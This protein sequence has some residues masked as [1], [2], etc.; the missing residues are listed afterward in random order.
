[1]LNFESPQ[2][3]TCGMFSSNVIIDEY[4][5]KPRMLLFL[6]PPIDKPSF[7]FP[8]YSHACL[9]LY[10]LTNK[11]VIKFIDK[12]FD[13]LLMPFA[14]DRNEYYSRKRTE[15]IFVF[16][17]IDTGSSVKDK[18]VINN[19]EAI[20]KFKKKIADLNLN[21]VSF[22]GDI[23]NKVFCEFIIDKLIQK[24]AFNLQTI[25]PGN[26]QTVSNELII[27]T[28][29]NVALFSLDHS[30]I[31]TFLGHYKDNAIS[32]RYKMSILG[33]KVFRM[34]FNHLDK[35]FIINFIYDISDSSRLTDTFSSI[36]I[37]IQFQD[38]PKPLSIIECGSFLPDFH[39]TSLDFSNN[40]KNLVIFVTYLSDGNDGPHRF[41]LPDIIFDLCLFS[42]NLKD[43][44]F[45]D[46]IITEFIY[47]L[48]NYYV[49]QYSCTNNYCTDCGSVIELDS[50]FCSNC[51]QLLI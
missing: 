18:L 19:E 41:K 24:G 13:K 42:G 2:D 5:L 21:V 34:Y 22:K 33:Y 40:D 37:K 46:S 35:L 25:T 10:S 26:S 14:S 12:N 1:M 39:G 43:V 3:H 20:T 17:E 27:C 45:T 48:E 44:D 28:E 6:F 38:S 50:L 31:E 16:I 15:Y 7:H 32:F 49:K 29:I 51:G 11:K 30:L 23:E 4:N 47:F 9:I 36:P 8:R